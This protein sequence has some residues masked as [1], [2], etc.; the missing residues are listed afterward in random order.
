MGA[1]VQQ[2]Y[3]FDLI[4]SLSVTLA[5]LVIAVG[6]TNFVRFQWRFR[7]DFIAREVLLRLPTSPCSADVSLSDFIE[8]A[9]NGQRLRWWYKKVDSA[10]FWTHLASFSAVVDILFGLGL[11]VGA[12]HVDPILRFFSQFFLIIV[13]GVSVLTRHLALWGSRD[14][15]CPNLGSVD[16]LDSQIT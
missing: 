3:Q 13:A 8:I 1:S 5:F 7:P 11:V 6:L 2:G 4:V 15:G 14:F 10:I 9:T 16:K 12:Y